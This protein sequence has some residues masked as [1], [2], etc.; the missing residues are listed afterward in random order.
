MDDCS[1]WPHLPTIEDQT[2]QQR[3]FELTAVIAA[4]RSECLRQ[5]KPYVIC[6]HA[7]DEHDDHGCT[8][9]VVNHGLFSANGLAQCPCGGYADDVSDE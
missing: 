2:T 1:A 3:D 7:R 8:A 5:I 4:S 6:G 9:K